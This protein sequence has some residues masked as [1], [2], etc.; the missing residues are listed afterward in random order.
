MDPLN[1][2]GY[3]SLLFGRPNKVEPPKSLHDLAPLQP[4]ERKE[5]SKPR[6]KKLGFV[7]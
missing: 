5:M 1:P 3:C 7:E 6:Q 2:R 4:W